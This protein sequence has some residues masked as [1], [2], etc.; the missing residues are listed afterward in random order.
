MEYGQILHLKIHQAI[1]PIP[2]FLPT[3]LE[4]VH[5]VFLNTF[6]VLYCCLFQSLSPDEYRVQNCKGFPGKVVQSQKANHLTLQKCAL[7]LFF[8]EI[9]VTIV[10]DHTFWCPEKRG[11]CWWESFWLMARIVYRFCFQQ[12]FDLLKQHHLY[13]FGIRHHLESI[14][15]FVM[16]NIKVSLTYLPNMF[17]SNKC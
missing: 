9:D 12:Y 1:H 7:F 16:T 4:I 13:T 17:N 5:Q 11:H 14:V 6:N 2:I 3:L 15:K 10:H 8:A